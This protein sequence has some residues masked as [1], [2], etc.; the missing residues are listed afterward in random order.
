MKKFRSSAAPKGSKLAAG[1]H[2]RTQSRTSAEEDEKATRVKALEEMVKLGQMDELTFQ[3]LRDEI[4][5]GDVKDVHLVKGLDYK[6]LK[7]VRLGEDVLAE[8]TRH[9]QDIQPPSDVPQPE[10]DVED[11]LEKLEERQVAP[12][13]R[14]ESTKRGDMAPPP[15]AAGRK[16]TRDDLMKELK[17]ARAAAAAEAK[18]RQPALGAKFKRLGEKREQSRIEKDGKGREVL[19]IIDEDGNVKK[20]VKKAEFSDSLGS[21]SGLLMPDKGAAPL[22]MEV[23]PVSHANLPQNEEVDIFEG[24]GTDFNLLGDGASGGDDSND[25]QVEDDDNDSDAETMKRK[26]GEVAQTQPIVSSPP[27]VKARN[28]FKDSPDTKEGATPTHDPLRDPAILAALKK[29]STIHAASSDAPENEAEAAKMARHKKLLESR[30]RDAEDLDM[31][32]G[33]SRFDDQEDGEEGKVKL[34]V[35][36]EGGGRD[37]WLGGKVAKEKRKRGSKKRKGDGNSAADVMK[38]LERRRGDKR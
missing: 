31:G 21:E 8:S 7:R 30:D 26:P 35:W 33:D 4:V 28:Y 6:L 38:V 9:H 17:A 22:G 15:A 36:G 11:E 24:V 32:F 29:A 12:K 18:A 16:R 27:G 13:K 1:Y 34:S 23:N 5:G 10:V 25:N 19:I 37:D 2:D 14:E 3:R 20:K